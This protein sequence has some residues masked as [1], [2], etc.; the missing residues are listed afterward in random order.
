MLKIIK[1]KAD[2]SSYL[3]LAL[4]IIKVGVLATIFFFVL[5]G[6]GLLRAALNEYKK[7]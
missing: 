5:T 6:V 3:Y 7:D 1:L 2:M 4:D